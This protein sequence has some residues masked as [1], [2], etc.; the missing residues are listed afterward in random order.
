MFILR[1]GNPE[2]STNFNVPLCL[3]D[4]LSVKYYYNHPLL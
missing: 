1:G 4:L 3:V 2:N